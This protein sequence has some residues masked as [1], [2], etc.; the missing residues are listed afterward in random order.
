MPLDVTYFFNTNIDLIVN[1]V[2][3]AKTRLCEK[4]KKNES[5]SSLQTIDVA[6]LDLCGLQT[7]DLEGIIQMSH[8]DN[9]VPCRNRK[10]LDSWPHRNVSI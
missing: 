10:P 2:Q 1:F 6:L 8:A 4:M 5:Y 3:K 7:Q 9:N